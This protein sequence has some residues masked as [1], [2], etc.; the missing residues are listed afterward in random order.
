MSDLRPSFLLSLSEK[1]ECGESLAAII[2]FY[3]VTTGSRLHG[4]WESGRKYR[5]AKWDTRGTLA[6]P[7]DDEER[8]PC[9]CPLG[10]PRA[11][12]WLSSSFP[13]SFSRPRFHFVLPLQVV[14]ERTIL[15]LE[16]PRMAHPTGTSNRPSWKCF[17]SLDGTALRSL[18]SA[19]G[20]KLCPESRFVLPS[21]T[22]LSWD[23]CGR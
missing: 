3:L 11:R 22:W 13:L 23:V 14:I 8:Y 9:V 15:T 5:K 2:L 21:L 6:K 7:Q 20:L 17:T 12:R 10:S 19:R 4:R 16:R 1:L 18:W